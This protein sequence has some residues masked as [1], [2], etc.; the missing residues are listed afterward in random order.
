M[1]Q[2]LLMKNKT[3]GTQAMS[4]TGGFILIEETKENLFEKK[5]SREVLNRSN[6][7]LT[8]SMNHMSEATLNISDVIIKIMEDIHITFMEIM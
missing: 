4:I 6:G 7:T 8:S 2:I 1:L 5:E 3:P